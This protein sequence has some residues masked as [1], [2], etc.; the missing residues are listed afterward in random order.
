MRIV[1]CINSVYLQGGMEKVTIVKANALARIPDNEVWIVVTDAQR[2]PIMPLEKVHLVNLDVRYYDK[3]VGLLKYLKKTRL[4]KKRLTE[5]L[6]IIKP[7]VVIATGQSEKGVIP[8]LKLNSNPVFVHELHFE[9]HYRTKGNLHGLKDK[10]FAWSADS[11]NN[12]W[13]FKRYDH[14]VIL[15]E[16][17]LH[18]NW[19]GWENVS[20]IPNPITAI[21]EKQSTCDSKTAIAVGRLV[22]Q[23]DFASLIRV[24]KKVALK[25]PDW[26]LEIWGEGGMQ[27]ALQQQIE[28]AGLDGKVCLMGYTKNISQKM[29]QASM[30]LLSSRYEGFPLVMIEAMS[31]G[32]PIVSYMCPTGPQDILDNGRTGFLVPMGDENTFA[33]KVC[34]LIEN[35]ILRKTMGEMALEESKEYSAENIVQRWMALFRNL[36]KQKH[37]SRL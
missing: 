28:E 12:Y 13:R 17:D 5:F 25:H 7:D 6:N 34:M 32:L 22:Y 1:Y 21:C 19:K 2:E 15:T 35:D 36:I 11:F 9:K 8:S 20:V 27:Q 4:H 29:S 23:K 16:E 14:I 31:V 37:E 18:K 24:W 30:F 26:R 33:E 10:F 3:N